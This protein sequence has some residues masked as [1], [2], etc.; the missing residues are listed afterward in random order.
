[1]GFISFSLDYYQNNIQE[2]ESSPVC[3]ERIYKAKQ[4]LK[5]LDDLKDEGYFYLCDQ[6]EEKYSGITRL[7]RY[8]ADNHVAPFEI[9][10]RIVDT[11]NLTYSD[12]K[13]DL[14]TM[15]KGIGKEVKP[16]PIKDP[17]P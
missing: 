2:F 1:M 16:Q 8:L 17:N 12:E 5:M 14:E 7:R 10:S 4:L 13:L 3:D 15:L 11:N 9:T 6:L